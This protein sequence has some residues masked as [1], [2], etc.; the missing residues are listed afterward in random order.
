MVILFVVLA[1]G[2]LIG[3]I[4]FLLPAYFI[5]TDAQALFDQPHR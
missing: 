2:A 3:C 5:L 4:V 1:V